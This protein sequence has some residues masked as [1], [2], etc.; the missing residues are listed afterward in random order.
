MKFE[1]RFPL[2]I[3]GI[4]FVLAALSLMY[5]MLSGMIVGGSDQINVGYALRGYAAQAM[6][7]TGHIPQWNPFI[8]GGMPLWEIPG[9]FDVF[10]PTAWLRWFLRADLVLTLSFFIHLVVAGLAMYSLLRTLRASWTASVTAGLAYELSGILASQLSPGHDGKLFAAALV[11][12]AFVALL[13]AIRGGRTG[14]YG[15]FAMVVGL[16]MLTPH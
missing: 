12:F 5:P 7:Q 11:P 16:V 4:I 8:F 15:W 1:P 6:Q 13:R 10:Y 14:S 9:H 3:A 2:L